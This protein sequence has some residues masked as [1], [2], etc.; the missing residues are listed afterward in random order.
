M[1]RERDQKTTTPHELSF[2][3]MS[4]MV[5]DD[6]KTNRLYLGALL[7]EFGF[8]V[9]EADGVEAALTKLNA[10]LAE[11]HLPTILIV[12]LYMPG[13]DGWTLIE[14]LRN[15]SGYDSV[16]CILM[17]SVGTRGDVERCQRLGIDGY[18]VKPVVSAEFLELLRRVVGQKR[19]DKSEHWPI[20]RHQ[21]R[22]E[23]VKLVLLLVDDVDVN[24]M[25]ARILLERMGHEVTIARSGREALEI[26]A[27]RTFDAIFMDV[28]MPEMDGL[29]ATGAIRERER[30]SGG[31][32]T[33]IIAM[34]AYALT[35]DRERCLAAGMD[36]Y[37]SKPI[38]MEKIRDALERNMGA[39]CH[40]D[41]PHD[42][43]EDPCSVAIT[44]SGPQENVQETPEIPV[45]DRAELLERLN[46]N[47]DMLN[48]FIGKFR[49]SA[50]GLLIA[51]REA[52]VRVDSAQVRIKAHAIKG[53]AANI[54]ARQMTEHA[55]AIEAK[56]IAGDLGGVVEM[57]ANLEAEFEEFDRESGSFRL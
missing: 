52:A 26:L 7:S 42:L 11:S 27:S 40:V 37:V 46:G 35:G 43:K 36:D 39:R 48:K 49:D 45:F 23:Q 24:L 47:S 20:T 16:H 9:S 30:L 17:P 8:V 34:T 22:E 4:A 25:V 3:G 38:K 12:D 33:P 29:Q 13:G 15:Q 5:V 41:K 44:T 14:K 50:E 51:L 1:L 28:Q 55:A 6:N 31:R 19:E 32:H 21:V 53:A 2:S 57:V 10:A 56:A 18:L 54:A